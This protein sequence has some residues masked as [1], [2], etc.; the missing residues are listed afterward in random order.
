MYVQDQTHAPGEAPSARLSL[1]AGLC[2]G[3]TVRNGSF[4]LVPRARV[5]LRKHFHVE[6]WLQ[7]TSG[8]QARGSGPRAPRA[9]VPSGLDPRPRWRLK[10]GCPPYLRPW[11]VDPLAA[12]RVAWNGSRSGWHCRTALEEE[13]LNLSVSCARQPSKPEVPQRLTIC[14]IRLLIWGAIG[15]PH[16]DPL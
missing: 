7:P 1:Q 10:T 5:Q 8:R 3:H 2:D 15:T 13:P 11:A 4:C 14:P 12:G 16:P 6:R 9:L